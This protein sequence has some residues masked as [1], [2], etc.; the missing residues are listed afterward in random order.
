LLEKQIGGLP[1]KNVE[2]YYKIMENMKKDPNPDTIKLLEGTIFPLEVVNAFMLHNLLPDIWDGAGG[3]YLG[4]DWSALG[5]LLTVLNI[6]EP[7]EVVTFLR[8][9]DGFTTKFKNEEMAKDRKRS[10]SRAPTGQGKGISV[11]G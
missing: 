1:Y 10:E 9:V 2:E 4:K 11:N 8:Y 7:K 6:N 3:N 5:S